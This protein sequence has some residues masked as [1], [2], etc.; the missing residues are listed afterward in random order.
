[1]PTFY[2]SSTVRITH[3]SMRVFDPEPAVY[4][5]ADLGPVWVVTPDPPSVLVRVSCSS[6]AVVVAVLVSVQQ[7]DHSMAWVVATLLL[8]MLA[9]LLP[10]RS[11]R[12]APPAYVIVATCRGEWVCLYSTRDPIEFGQVRRAL[13]RAVEWHDDVVA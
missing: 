11:R 6:G 8:G 3:R 4:L 12:S 9:P 13:Q 10:A 2:N 5:I 7:P 1:M